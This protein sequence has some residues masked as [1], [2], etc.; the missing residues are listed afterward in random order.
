MYFWVK[1]TMN[2]YINKFKKKLSNF[3]YFKQKNDE[4]NSNSK[5]ALYSNIYTIS[6]PQKNKMKY[7]NMKN[8]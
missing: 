5:C 1:N 2:E 8:M 7:V 3:K 4:K 6:P